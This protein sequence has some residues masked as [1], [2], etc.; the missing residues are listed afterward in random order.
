MCRNV[1]KQCLLIVLFLTI[2]IEAA[3][4]EYLTDSPDLDRP[5]RLTELEWSGES[6]QKHSAMQQDLA[7][8]AVNNLSPK[9]AENILDVGCGTGILL[10]AFAHKYP[11]A[12]S[13]SCIDPNKSMLRQAAFEMD[14]RDGRLYFYQ[15][16]GQ[17]FN[18]NR[19]FDLVIS[20]LTF[21]WIPREDQLKT[22]KNIW[23]HMNPGGTL[24]V[25]TAA[26]KRQLPL[27]KALKDA[28]SQPPYQEALK[29]FPSENYY[30]T[31]EEYR[32]W[33]KEAGF[34][35]VRLEMMEQEFWYPSKQA[36][37]NFV[38]SFLRQGKYIKKVSPELYE[39]FM[40]LMMDRF[41]YYIDQTNKK[42]DRSNNRTEG[43]IFHNPNIVIFA[44]KPLVKS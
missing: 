14:S 41:V 2:G 3:R 38:R 9:H 44:Q 43:L 19:Q 26:D 24:A 37:G 33:L 34:E 39:G 31:L 32:Q 27:G 42:V 11:K 22:L 15:A 12:Q 23:E 35:I 20:S 13:Y 40:S 4:A 1:F 28:I 10:K 25:L 5:I 6:Y 8:W 30:F 16:T 18:I 21:H 17:S 36:L 29:N 7:E